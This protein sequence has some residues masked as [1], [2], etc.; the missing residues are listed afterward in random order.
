MAA[1]PPPVAPCHPN[2]R[3][4]GPADI[5]VLMIRTSGLGVE[6]RPDLLSVVCRHAITEPTRAALRR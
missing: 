6:E 1:P 2:A 4:P 5:A 3:E